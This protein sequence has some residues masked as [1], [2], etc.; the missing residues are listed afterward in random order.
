[1]KTSVF[2]FFLG[3]GILI[4]IGLVF[5]ICKTVNSERYAYS[6]TKLQNVGS[7]PLLSDKPQQVFI[8][9]EVSNG[10]DHKYTTHHY[11]RSKVRKNRF[12]KNYV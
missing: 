4:C 9:H 5:L 3:V 12:Q 2:L 10:D 1:M 8:E 11:D 6:Y 7:H